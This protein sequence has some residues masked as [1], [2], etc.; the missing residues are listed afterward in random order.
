MVPRGVTSSMVAAF[1]QSLSK[2]F[3]VKLRESRRDDFAIS[4]LHYV[5][6]LS[7]S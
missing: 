4:V 3:V 5:H 1:N 6:R 7:T 2:V